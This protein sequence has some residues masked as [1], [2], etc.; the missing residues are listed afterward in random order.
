MFFILP[1][2]AAQ[3]ACNTIANIILKKLA[4]N[5]SP[6]FKTKSFYFSYTLFAISMIISFYILSEIKF[7]YVNALLS[8]N[9]ICVTLFSSIFLGDTIDKK[10]ILGIALVA[11]GIFVFLWK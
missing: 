5:K 2:I 11:L 6:H 4:M 9:Y 10:S 7:K 3:I 8:A 1:L